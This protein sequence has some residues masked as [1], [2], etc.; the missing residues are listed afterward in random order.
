[1]QSRAYFQHESMNTTLVRFADTVLINPRRPHI[2]RGDDVPT[3]FVGM[4]AVDEQQGEIRNPEV[5]PFAAVAKGYTYFEEGDVLFAKITPCMQ[6]GKQAVASGLLDGIGFGSTEFHVFRPLPGLDSRWLLQFLRQETV[7]KAAQRA[8]TGSVGQQRV[9]DSFFH[10]LEIPVPPLET[11][12]EL[13]ANLSE[14]L[15]QIRMSRKGTEEQIELIRTLSQQA[16]FRDAF[17]MIGTPINVG[18]SRKSRSG[19]SSIPLQAI[20]RLESG[21][22]PSRR[23]PEWW[24]GSVPWLALPD[25]RKLHG[26]YAAETTEYTNDAGIANSSARLLPAGT[27]CVSRTASIGFVTILG[28]PMATSQDFCNWV[29]DPDKLDAEFLMCAFMA[30]QDYLKELGSGAVHKTIYMQTIESFQVWAPAIEE[31]RRMASTV[32]GRL[33]AAESLQVSLASRLAEIEK[34]PQ[35]ILASAFGAH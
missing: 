31:Q 4:S 33:A 19:W 28:R 18:K 14:A 13:L 1:M 5:R 25:I 10:D 2:K 35:R 12:Q 27:V 26:K 23:H 24:G 9:P 15:L 8:Y 3:T 6:N 17:A 34:F 11:Q 22:T 32:L 16:L 21:H 20:A 7:L 29:C 30:S